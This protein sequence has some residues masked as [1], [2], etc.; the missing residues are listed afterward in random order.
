M[1]CGRSP[2]K[3]TQTPSPEAHRQWAW[4]SP[5]STPSMSMGFLSTRTPSPSGIPSKS[6]ERCHG[7]QYFIQLVAYLLFFSSE[8]SKQKLY[9]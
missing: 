9:V 3:D 4:T 2:S 5:S 6:F 1:G 8:F 7:N